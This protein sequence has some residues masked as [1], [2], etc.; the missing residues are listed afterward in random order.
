MKKIFVFG[1][2]ISHGVWDD[3][4]GGWVS[5]LRLFLMSKSTADNWIETYELGVNGDIAEKVLNRLEFEAY[6]RAMPEDGSIFLV[7]IG[8]NDSV[9]FKSQETNLVSPEEFR[10]NLQYIIALIKKNSWQMAFV[11]LTPVNEKMIN[12]P[13]IS[14]ENNYIEKYDGIIKSV[15]ERN[16][17]LFIDIFN[18]FRKDNYQNLLDED[19][20]HPNANGHQKIFEIV[21]DALI[22]SSLI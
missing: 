15:C 12:E 4:M 17:L 16:E 7:N 13:G 11:G 5:R 3:E 20:L 2:S 18:E 10:E 22:K 9:F 19:G 8:I 6:Q 21:R 14:Y 1:D